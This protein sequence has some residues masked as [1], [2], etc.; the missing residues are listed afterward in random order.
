MTRLLIAS[1]FLVHTVIY[2][3]RPSRAKSNRGTFAGYN[4]DG[5][6]DV[7]YEPWEGI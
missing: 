7:P 1:L 5:P 6:F 2:L 4:Y 3:L